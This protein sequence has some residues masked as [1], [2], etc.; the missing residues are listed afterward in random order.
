MNVTKRLSVDRLRATSDLDEKLPTIWSEVGETCRC[1]LLGTSS[2]LIS[3]PDRV[4][5]SRTIFAV[6]PKLGSTSTL[7]QTV[8]YVPLAVA[9]THAEPTQPGVSWVTPATTLLGLLS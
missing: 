5:W 3:N 1:E 9:V 2:E 8:G 6:M 4:S 7:F